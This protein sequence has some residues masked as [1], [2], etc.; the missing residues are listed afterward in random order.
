V[1]RKASANL[2]VGRSIQRHGGI[3]LVDWEQ[4]FNLQKMGFPLQGAFCLDLI[5]GA[6]SR[7]HLKRVGGG[8]LTLQ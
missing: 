5:H 1:G 4:K 8:M 2:S 6:G 3:T 7:K